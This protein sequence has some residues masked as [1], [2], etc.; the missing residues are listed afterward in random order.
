MGPLFRAPLLAVVLAV[1][2]ATA[3]RAST[4]SLDSFAF[5]P[6]AIEAGAQTIGTVTLTGPAAADTAVT[7]QSGDPTT[8]QVP[9]SVVVPAGMSQASFAPT[10]LGPSPDV[11]VTASLDGVDRQAH[12]AIVTSELQSISVR[13]RAIA[14]GAT[15]TATITLTSA[16]ASPKTVMLSA[17]T[18][19]ASVPVSVQVPAGHRSTTFL[20]SGTSSGSAVITATLGAVNSSDTV[21]VTSTPHLVLNEVDYDNIGTDFHEFVEVY[22]P[23]GTTLPLDHLAIVGVNGSNNAEYLRVELDA[24]TSIAPDHYLVVAV[25]D[26]VNLAPGTPLIP[27]PATNVVQNGPPDGLALVDTSTNTVLDALSYEGSITAA[28]LTGFPTAVDLVEGTA[29]NP[30]V[31]DSNTVDGS[32]IR[33]PNGSDTGDAATD[34]SFKAA[35]PSPGGANETPGGPVPTNNPNIPPGNQPPVFDPLELPQP[36]TWPSGKPLA[37][38]FNAVDPDGDPVSYRFYGVPDGMTVDHATQTLNWTPTDAELGSY[39]IWISATDQYGATGFPWLRIMFTVAQGRTLTVDVAG[40][41]AGSVAS[42]PSGIACPGAC[43]LRALDGT[44]ITLTPAAASGSHFTGWTGACT[45]T[46]GCTA[47]LSGGDAVVTATFAKDAAGETTTTTATPTPPTTT[48]TAAPPPAPTPPTIAAPET[49]ITRVKVIG[50]SATV[51]FSGTGTA[52][53][54]RLDKRAYQTCRSPLTLRRI[55]PGRHTF[56][57]R[58]RTTAGVRDPTPATRTIVVRK[59]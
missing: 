11:T 5:D 17:S 25:P 56:S 24:A 48:T 20:V 32:L 19:A 59:R 35:N 57:V 31:A 44:D 15:S 51:R 46:G 49:T 40:D 37:I 18:A 21:N 33:L 10:I 28:T 45:G 34:W 43:T 39:D 6:S 58:T 26:S 55:K 16:P 36:L 14:P 41:G 9:T 54:C 8:V 38:H 12:L 53:E 3:A 4:P 30:S 22:N 2:L 42:D 52:F 13:P 47:S 27:L 23:T 7:L 50:R 1:L 29:L